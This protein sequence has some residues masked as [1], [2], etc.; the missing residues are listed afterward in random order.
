VAHKVV[1]A[2]ALSALLFAE[3]AAERV[4]QRLGAG[5]LAAP[6]LLPYEVTSVGLK[7]M[8]RYPDRRRELLGAL[9]LFPRL[10]IAMVAIPVPELASLAGD[11]G[12]TVYDAAYLW[13]A[14]HLGAELV[15]LDEE[16]EA[17]WRSLA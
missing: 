10:G 8:R 4:V 12:L 5:P 17:A 6:S 16:L 2:S 15:T 11:T 7:K 14:R 13:L 3:P 1:D 9:E